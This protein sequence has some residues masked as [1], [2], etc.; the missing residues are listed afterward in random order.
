MKKI[1]VDPEYLEAALKNA[2][3]ELKHNRKKKSEIRRGNIRREKRRI[4][5]KLR[6]GENYK[7]IRVKYKDAFLPLTAPTDF[8]F[9]NNC[10]EVLEYMENA[11]NTINQGK[12]IIFDFSDI[13]KLSPDGIALLISNVKDKGFNRGVQIKGRDPKKQEL[14]QMFEESGFY[15]H[16]Y[17]VVP[18]HKNPNNMLLHKITRHRTEPVLAK[19]ICEKATLHTL[20]QIKK[21]PPLYD[22]L[23]E[24]MTNTHNHA[25]LKQKGVHDW[26]IFHYCPL[27][28]TIS[29]FAFIDLGVGI[30]RSIAVRNYVNSVK[31]KLGFK[32]N[33]DLVNDLLEGKITSRTGLEIRGKGFPTIYQHTKNP[34]IKNF[35]LISNDVYANISSGIYK[36][37]K[38]EFKGTFL[39][40]EFHH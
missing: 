23:V 38:A 5:E 1:L 13:D 6:L 10:D 9:V 39:Y 11:R 27:N 4:R 16:V 32:A 8:S 35:V 21:F 17:P 29:Y 36:E 24:C 19:E 12:Q 22:I 15:D 33:V 31:I 14:K 28:S 34:A 7:P 2:R 37:T 20:G 40:W 3:K 25:N 18:R 30:F 26:W